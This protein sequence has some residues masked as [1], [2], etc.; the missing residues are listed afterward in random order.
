[1][2]EGIDVL[3]LI[4]DAPQKILT[5]TFE[6]EG[7][8]FKLELAAYSRAEIQKLRRKGIRRVFDRKNREWR[9]EPDDDKIQEELAKAIHG[10]EGLTGSKLAHYCRKNPNISIDGRREAMESEIPCDLRYRQF[11]LKHA[12]CLR[13][14]GT[15]LGFADWVLEQLTGAADEMAVI[16]EKKEAG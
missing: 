16:E 3:K 12:V 8:S 4:E 2:G 6:S 14:G 1:M 9:D 15:M 13:D 5:P 11:I 7:E 10:W